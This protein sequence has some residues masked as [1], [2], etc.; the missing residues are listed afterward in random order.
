MVSGGQC[1]VPSFDLA[2]Q[3]S[4]RMVMSSEGPYLVLHFD[5]A[6]Q[7]SLCN[8]CMVFVMGRILSWPRGNL[9]EDVL[10]RSISGSKIDRAEV[11]Q[12]GVLWSSL[13]GS[14]IRPGSTKVLK[15]LCFF[16]MEGTSWPS[17]SVRED[18][19]TVI[20]GF[21]DLTIQETIRELY[22]FMDMI[23]FWSCR[24]DLWGS[25]PGS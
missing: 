10:E 6:I 25:F 11:F 8:N 21:Q 15:Q 1:L 3:K 2:I 24:D 17:S 4:F 16:I 5:F 22:V 14:R 19:L 13:L 9:R 18:A 12:Y 20:A 23:C 7:N